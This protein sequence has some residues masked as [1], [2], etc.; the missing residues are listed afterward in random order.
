MGGRLSWLE[1]NGAVT[2]VEDEEQLR[3]NHSMDSLEGVG[4]EEI[5]QNELQNAQKYES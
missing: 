3:N 1:T 4:T 5:P 2:E